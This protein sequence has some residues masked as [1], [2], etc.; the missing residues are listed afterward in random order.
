MDDEANM[1]DEARHA[2]R[3][4]ETVPSDGDSER[5]ETSLQAEQ[6]QVAV[7]CC[8]DK[9]LLAKAKEPA[10]RKISGVRKDLQLTHIMVIMEMLSILR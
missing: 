7:P 2:P 9:S 10:Q 5:P 8:I 1:T 4:V 6:L 3:E